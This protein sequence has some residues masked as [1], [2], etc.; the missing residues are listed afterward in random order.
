[1]TDS[2]AD[3]VCNAGKL[4]QHKYN[5]CEPVVDVGLPFIKCHYHRALRLPNE[6]IFKIEVETDSGTNASYIMKLLFGFRIRWLARS[7]PNFLN[8]QKRV[9]DVG[10]G[11]GQF[12]SYLKSK[13][14]TKTLGVEPNTSRRC[15]AIKRGINVLSDLS[16]LSEA[17]FDLI[18]VW[19]VLEH[20][21]KPLLFLDEITS[22]LADGGSIIISIPNHAGWQ[23]R[24]F[25][26]FSCYLDYGRHLWY[27]NKDITLLMEENFKDFDVSIVKGH[28]LEYEVFGWVDTLASF[29]TRS[30]NFIHSHIK[31][32]ITDKNKR[33]IPLFLM[34]ILLPIS[35]IL[36]VT[37]PPN[38]SSTLTIIIKPNKNKR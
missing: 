19:H 24:I 34:F 35:V 13:G 3:E 9:L 16:S 5:N 37:I 17:E 1:M 36:S 30:V 29:I 23:T 12:L 8:I 6:N 4:C 21:E 2:C 20:V 7:I 18:F 11:D 26:V 33:F 25:G 28:N 38:W 10:C 27:W 15:N 22:L 31:K 32:K 14:Y